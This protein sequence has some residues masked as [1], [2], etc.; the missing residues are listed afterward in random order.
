MIQYLVKRIAVALLTIWFIAT[1]TF[2]AMHAVPG[3]PLAADKSLPPE[4]KQQ[5][6]QHYGL[7]DPLTVQY[8]R[9]IRNAAQGELGY[10]YTQKNRAVNDIIREHFPVSAA[11]GLLALI[12]AALIAMPLGTLAALFYKRTIDWGIMSLVILSISVPG[13]VIAAFAQ[14]GILQINSL[15]GRQ[16]PIAGASSLQHLLVPALVLG[17][18]TCAYMTRLMRAH[19]LSLKDSEFMLSAKA[20]HLPAWQRF[21]GHHFRTAVLPVIAILGPAIAALTTGGFVIETVFAIPG[22]GRYF[23]QAVQQLD[24]TTIMGTTVFYGAFLVLI[25][26]VL[27]IF[28]AWLDPRVRLGADH[29]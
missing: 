20:R 24:Y 27:D 16:W 8:W 17:A 28:Y 19:L 15:L 9:F 1:A 26:L 14:L 25:V 23:I 5:L 13:F 11:L 21:W 29:E 3:D 2:F 7:H 10:S 22:L 4:I 12:F 6:E 18:G